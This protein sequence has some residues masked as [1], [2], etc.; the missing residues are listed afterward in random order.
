MRRVPLEVALASVVA[1]SLAS[2]TAPVRAATFKIVAADRM[3]EGFNDTTPR[4]PVGGNPG[5]TLGAQR[6]NVIRYATSLWGADLHSNVQI[7]LAVEFGPFAPTECRSSSALLG[8]AGPTTAFVNF[9]GA[10]LR[11]TLYPSALADSLAGTDL[12]PGA[13]DISA[14]FNQDIDS[15]CFSIGAPNGWYYGYDNNP[16]PGTLNLLQ[17]VLH[18]LVHGLGF[19]SFVS[20]TG[21]RCC[22]NNP[23]DD[24]F[25]MNLEWHEVGLPWTLLTDEERIASTRTVDGLH[26]IGPAVR[27]ASDVISSG[28][29]ADHVHMFAPAVYQPGAS[30]SHFST[31]I[32]PNELLEPYLARE[33]RRVLSLKALEDMGWIPAGAVPP[34]PTATASATSTPTATR[35]ATRTATS[36]PSPTPTRTLTPTATHTVKRRE[37]CT[38]DCNGDGSVSINEVQLVANIYLAVSTVANCPSADVGADGEVSIQEVQR[39]SNEYLRGCP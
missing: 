3:G 38:T 23:M 2:A 29:T 7:R 13:P 1:I 11:N 15:G 21:A 5:T 17:T 28:R 18:E 6:L 37:T 33:A 25:M 4:A 9:N 26:W 32:F 10:P 35:S 22:G 36:P 14:A 20:E 19:A 39:A 27:S 24:V 12:N 31:D 30:V 16:P 8:Y 34:T